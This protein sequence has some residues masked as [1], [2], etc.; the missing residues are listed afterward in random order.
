MSLLIVFSFITH[1]P[2]PLSID[3]HPI[4]ACDDVGLT[5]PT[6]II[7][8]N[9]LCDVWRKLNLEKKRYTFKRNHSKS[10]IDFVLVTIP[11]YGEY[12]HL[13]ANWKTS[14]SILKLMTTVLVTKCFR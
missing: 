14:L 7:E 1:T 4:H 2:G 11:S 9:Y 6:S 5:E 8:K 13:K 10:R 12:I 3:R